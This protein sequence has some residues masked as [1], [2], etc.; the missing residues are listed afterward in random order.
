M[1]PK[2]VGRLIKFP[3]IFTFVL[4]KAKKLT[5]TNYLQK[6][7][8]KVIDDIRSLKITVFNLSKLVTDNN[9]YQSY[10]YD[11]HSHDYHGNDDSELSDEEIELSDEEIDD[12][13]DSDSE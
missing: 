4:Y 6:V 11:N 13:T 9:E 12:D 3:L 1:L 7:I 8:H 5:K 10:Y 2:K